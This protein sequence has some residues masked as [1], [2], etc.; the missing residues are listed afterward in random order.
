MRVGFF[1]GV[2]EIGGN[3][4]LIEDNGFGIVFDFGKRFKTNNT[5]FNDNISGRPE[6]GVDDYVEMGEFPPFKNFYIDSLSNANTINVDIGAVFFSHAHL[7]HIGNV[8]LINNAIPKY[9]SNESYAVLKY[10]V[11]FGYIKSMP[12]NVNVINKAISFGSFKVMPFPVDHDIPGALA[13][14]IET[15]KGIVIYTGDIFFKGISKEKSYDFVNYAKN[16]KPYLLIS[17]GTRIGWGGITSLTEEDLQ[18]EIESCMNIFKGMVIANPYEPHAPRIYSFYKVSQKFG[19]K[20]VLTTQYAY[21]LHYLAMAGN[22]IAQEILDSKNTFIYPAGT[23][24]EDLKQIY[25]NKFIDTYSMQN[26]QDNVLLLLGFRNTP[27]LIDIEPKKGSIYIHSGGEPIANIDGD[28][29]AILMNWLNK[30]NI[31]YFRIHSPGHAS[32]VEILQMAR[33]INPEIL[34]PIHTQIPERFKFITESIE[35]LEKGVLEEF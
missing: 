15:P 17:E 28:N 21:A 3:I 30:F 26:E 32:E 10:F 29:A 7:D 34:L 16:L 6:K 24:L 12:S 19:R 35:I 27:E 18:L 9:L 4:I 8:N 31:P 33:E 2:R 5:F 1:G 25:P 23:E 11:K 20:L 22:L 14:I 13:F